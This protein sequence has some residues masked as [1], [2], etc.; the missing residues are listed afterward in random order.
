MK[1]FKRLLFIAM[2]L[3][4][5]TI[6]SVAYTIPDVAEQEI[7]VNKI[8]AEGYAEKTIIFTD[9]VTVSATNT[10]T[11][12]GTDNVQVFAELADPATI[13]ATTING[14]TFGNFP[15]LSNTG[16]GAVTIGADVIAQNGLTVNE[17]LTVNGDLTV[18]GNLIISAGNT[19]TVTGDLTVLR[20]ILQCGTPGSGS[21]ATLTVSGNIVHDGNKVA[22]PSGDMFFFLTGA[23]SLTAHNVTIQNITQTSGT[24]VNLDTG[25]TMTLTGS[26][27]ISD[28]EGRGDDGVLLRNTLN[29]DGD[30]TF[31]RCISTSAGGAGIDGIFIEPT[32][33]MKAAT[34]SITF[35]QNSSTNG[36]AVLV[37]IPTTPTTN[38][39]EALDII[40]DNNVTT[41]ANK[42][43][44]FVNPNR[45]IIADQDIIF[46]RNTGGS[47]GVLV[48]D[49]YVK[50]LHNNVRFENNTGGTGEAGVEFLHTTAITIDAGNNI[51]LINNTGGAGGNG[52]TIDADVTLTATDTITCIGNTGISGGN[53]ITNAG[54]L[55]A[56]TIVFQDNAGTL[57]L[58]TTGTIIAQD[59][60]FDQAVSV[61]STINSTATLE[62]NVAV[63]GDFTLQAAT[64]LNIVGDFCVF[65]GTVQGD[66]SGATNALLNVVGDILFDG[67]TGVSTDD[68]FIR[69][70]GTSIIANNFTIINFAVS[71][72]AACNIEL[73]GGAP[74]ITLTGNWEIANLIG[75]GDGAFRLNIPVTLGGDVTINNCQAI[76][77]ATVGGNV[78]HAVELR[79]SGRITAVSGTVKILD[80][81]SAYGEAVS[82]PA[83]FSML[84]RDIIFADND[85]SA[86]LGGGGTSGVR[87]DAATITATNSLQ[88]ARNVGSGA[89]GNGTT[90]GVNLIN[91]SISTKDLS[92]IADCGGSANQD[93]GYN[94]GSLLQYYGGGALAA[95]NIL[96][97][98]SNGCAIDTTP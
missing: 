31:Y 73:I 69:F 42:N 95:G 39:I 5:A 24:A 71:F 35:M 28:V 8:L 68:R 1:L 27:L 60:I 43:G 29:V 52:I 2:P 12:A 75:D 83:G 92:I 61:G 54:T 90:F 76:D 14:I 50:A 11:V 36:H 56:L 58:N 19:V 85:G 62:G 64:Q 7:V 9:A 94:G 32:A 87:I 98:N 38:T 51:F 45:R 97:K 78:N 23:S 65:R 86:N 81:Q 84:A 47:A 22:G 17:D 91:T 40:F 53:G 82:I 18:Q 16:A 37:D 25:T 63:Y 88:F 30:I 70:F 34:G 3:Y 66:N 57:A 93:V 10:L 89:T 21:G 59:I 6:L 55:D 33:I 26:L 72:G 15:V 79:P 48:S 20:G 80:A 4:H 74:T 96:T 77:Q 13:Q 44:V 67:Q 41:A 46:T 49:G